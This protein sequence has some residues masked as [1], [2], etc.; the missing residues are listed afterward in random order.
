MNRSHEVTQT[1]ISTLSN[2]TQALIVAEQKKE[3]DVLVKTRIETRVKA[4]ATEY[5]K[6]TTVNHTADFSAVLQSAA[7]ELNCNGTCVS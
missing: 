2:E 5:Q 7:T 4:Y 6:A 3:R 1:F